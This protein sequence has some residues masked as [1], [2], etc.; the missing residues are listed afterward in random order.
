[1][2]IQFNTPAQLAAATQHEL[3]IIA[4]VCKA[5]LHD[6]NR[7]QKSINQRVHEL[8]A[9]YGIDPYKTAMYKQAEY[10]AMAFDNVRAYLK[11]VEAY[12][13]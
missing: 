11:T 7:E 3:S 9:E 10:N 2:T 12:Q 8:A 1:M 13:A 6:L 4:N 5:T